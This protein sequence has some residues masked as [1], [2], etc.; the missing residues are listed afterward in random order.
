MSNVSYWINDLTTKQL[1]NIIDFG[2][3]LGIYFEH[4]FR[5][6]TC[7]IY[8][9]LYESN[10]Q[11]ENDLHTRDAINGTVLLPEYEYDPGA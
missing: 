5:S 9:A 10:Y 6:F 8:A 1:T 2:V 4:I 3:K 7:I 11:I